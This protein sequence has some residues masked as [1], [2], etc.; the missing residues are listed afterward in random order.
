MHIAQTLI[1]LCA[2]ATHYDSQKISPLL[3]NRTIDINRM[4]ELALQFMPTDIDEL[5]DELLMLLERRN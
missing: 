3:R 4:L 2:V 5:A 1:R